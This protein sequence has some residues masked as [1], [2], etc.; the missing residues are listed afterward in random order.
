MG[1]VHLTLQ[2]CQKAILNVIRNVTTC[3]VFVNFT[4]NES[5]IRAVV[6]IGSQPTTQGSGART[7]VLNQVLLYL[8]AHGSNIV[9][10]FLE[11]SQLVVL[12]PAG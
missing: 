6:Q 5:C 11:I 12:T 7:Y 4:E 10:A 2:R 9:N 1:C 3:K 8:L